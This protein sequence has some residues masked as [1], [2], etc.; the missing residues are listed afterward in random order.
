MRTTLPI[1]DD[2]LSAVKEIGRAEHRS[3]GHV[4][5]DLVRKALTQMAP[6]P[7]GGESFGGFRPFPAGGR[8]VTDSMIDQIRSEE[9]I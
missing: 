6:E 8:V 2:V 4:I 5:S 1:D 3:A 7:A 9:G